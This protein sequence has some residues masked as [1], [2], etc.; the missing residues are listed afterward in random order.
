MKELQKFDNFEDMKA[1][2]DERKMEMPDDEKIKD[3][4][5]KLRKAKLK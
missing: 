4:I 1:S 3:L 2:S 5:N